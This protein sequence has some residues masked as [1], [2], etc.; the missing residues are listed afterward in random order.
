MD[1][2][3]IFENFTDGLGVDPE[4]VSEDKIPAENSQETDDGGSPTG[5]ALP[6]YNKSTGDWGP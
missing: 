6:G 2:F 3:E 4:Y 1:I 5:G